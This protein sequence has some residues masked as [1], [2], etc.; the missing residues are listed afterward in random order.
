MP[1][2]LRPRRLLF[3]AVVAL[4]AAF[5]TAAGTTA[6]T[7]RSAPA[8]TRSGNSTITVGVQQGYNLLPMLVGIREGY[9]KKVGITDVKF[10]LFASIPAM[11][12]AVAQ[13]QLDVGGQS[14][15]PLIAYN[16]ATSG[17]K[18]KML[19]TG[20]TGSTMWFAGTKTGLPSA[21]KADWKKAVLAWK[22]K[23][24]GIPAPKGLIEL[25]TNR[26]LKDVGLSPSDVTYQVVGV[27]PPAVAALKQGLVDVI[28]GDA[29]T[30]G[31]LAPDKAGYA[32]LSFPNGQG[33]TDLRTAPA[34][35]WFASQD[36]VTKDP[37]RFMAFANGWAKARA[38][39]ANPKNKKNVLDLLV[40]KVGLS[41]QEAAAIYPVGIPPFVIAKMSRAIY[42]Q[43]LAT[44]VDA[45][46]VP[47]PVPSFDDNVFTFAK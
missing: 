24:I 6:A 15:P 9:F 11:F 44:L 10:T 5:S 40:R 7:S 14:I 46:V 2:Q 19:V 32:V 3:V 8:A 35:V 30:L 29:L 34:G 1:N 39:L 20:T 25:Y 16:R 23:K 42:T 18:L 43:S 41:P 26:L 33:P 45:G 17:S 38:Y 13:G 28:S 47:G 37:A 31:L 21:T 4:V 22:G 36:S 12:A 27:G